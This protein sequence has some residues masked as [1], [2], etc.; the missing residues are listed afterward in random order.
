MNTNKRHQRGTTP[1][2]IGKWVD[3]MYYVK[4]VNQSRLPWVKDLLD[5]SGFWNTIRTD[6]LDG[7]EPERYFLMTN[8]RL[9]AYFTWH[10]FA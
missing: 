3:G 1:S 4:T 9:V 8:S 2:A 10:Y 5:L 6:R 7:S